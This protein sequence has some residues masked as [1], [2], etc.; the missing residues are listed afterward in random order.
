MRVEVIVLEKIKGLKKIVFKMKRRKG[1]RKWKGMY[2][3]EFNKGIIFG[4][5]VI[6]DGLVYFCYWF[7]LLS[8]V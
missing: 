5:F 6:L 3:M 1:Y 8:R 2:I 7:I 4:Y